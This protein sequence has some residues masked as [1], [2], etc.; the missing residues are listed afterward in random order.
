MLICVGKSDVDQLFYMKLYQKQGSKNKTGAIGELFALKYLIGCGHSVI[1][2]NYLRK[3]GEIDLITRVGSTVHFVEVKTVSY[4]TK[5][6]L[7]VAVSRGTYRPEENVHKDKFIKVARTAETWI[8][9]NYWQSAWQIDVM[10]V[11]IVPREKYATIN[12][13]ENVIFD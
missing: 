9:E 6:K 4:E 13:I 10:A 8:A 2:T 11:R 5:S 7:E 12:F 1:D 3:L